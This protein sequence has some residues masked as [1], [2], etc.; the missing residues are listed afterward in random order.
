MHFWQNNQD[1]LSVTLV[2]GE[3]NG[4]QNMS[5]HTRLTME[6]K[7]LQLLLPGLEPMTF[8]SD[9]ESGVLITELSLLHL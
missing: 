1:V 8:P 5:Q 7:T 6:Y 4:Y 9:Q 3:L 2:T